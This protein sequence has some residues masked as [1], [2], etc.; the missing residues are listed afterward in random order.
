MS[1]LSI[2]KL[3]YR[4]TD[5][6]THRPRTEIVYHVTTSR[7]VN[8]IAF[9]RQTTRKH[10]GDDTLVPCL[11]PADTPYQEEIFHSCDMIDHLNLD[12]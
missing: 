6:Q 2:R 11:T 9:R 5:R 12:I 8:K 3:D 10:N 7:V 4:L 1:R